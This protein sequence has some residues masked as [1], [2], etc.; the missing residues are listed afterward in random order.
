MNPHSLKFFIETYGCQMNTA[1]SDSLKS[2][3]ADAGF[4]EVDSPLDAD[5]AILNT[6]SVRLTAEERIEGR[7]GYYRGLKRDISVVLT[8]CMGQN[9]GLEIKRKFPDVVKL[10]WGTYNK[11]GLVSA[12]L[13]ISNSNDY[14][15]QTDY[16]FMPAKPQKKY[17]FKAFV[18]VSHGC[19]NFC[20]YCIVPYV[21]GREISR[22]S[23]EIIENVKQLADEGVIEFCLLGQNVNSYRDGATGFPSLL[24][25]IANI[26]GVER[27][28]FLTS[29]PKDF[30]RELVGAI[31]ANPNV[32]RYIHLPFQ[33]GSNRVLSEMNRKYTREDYLKKIE[34]AREIDDVVITTDIMVGFPGETDAEFE[35]TMDIV[36]RVRFNEAYMYRYNIRPGTK[37]E[38]LQNQVDEETKLS[39]LAR[40]IETQSR[41]TKKILPGYTGRVYRSLVE[42]VSKKDETRLCARTHNGIM[43]FFKGDKSLIG[44]IVEL[45]ITGV[46]G[47]G[48]TAVIL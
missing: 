12:L 38:K 28:T 14:L 13:N 25:K 11:E 18:P 33:A 4:C 30:S 42:S 22:K 43:V 39:R 45:E 41:I 31:N 27:L 21:R 48:L 35:D 37:A 34:T 46:S 32:M 7:I 8:G 40:L 3:L 26:D 19:D 9:V 2:I 20:S 23:G 10:V 24:D 17:P 47:T 44:R 15:S 1:E 29:H 6:C 36:E 16:R 5:F